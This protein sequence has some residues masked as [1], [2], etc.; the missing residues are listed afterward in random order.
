MIALAFSA[1]TR[2]VTSFQPLVRRQAH[3]ACVSSSSWIVTSS[4]FS[5]TFSRSSRLHSIAD[6]VTNEMKVAMKAKDQIRLNI[7]RLIRA[8]FANAQIE[9]KVEQLSDTQAQTVLRKMAK[10]RQDSIQ[11]YASNNAPDR[12]AIEQAELDVIESWLPQM[13]DEDTTRVWVQEAI[14]SLQSAQQGSNVGKVMGALMK[15]HK[16]EL[17]GTLAQRLV[18]EEVAKRTADASA[19]SSK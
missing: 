8:A 16:M 2:I 18:K 4:P 7:I 19:D 1:G 12:A 10:M 14:Q 17:D 11:M 5:R 6:D 9:H 15:E 13:A 3:H